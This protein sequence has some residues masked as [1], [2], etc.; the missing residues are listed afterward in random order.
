MKTAFVSQK[1]KF[2]KKKHSTAELIEIG[3]APKNDKIDILLVATTKNI[4]KQFDSIIR[5]SG[6]KNSIFDAEPISLANCLNHN[7]GISVDLSN[8]LFVLSLENQP[9]YL[10]KLKI[11]TLRS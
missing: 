11:H 10:L 3:F 6:F 5:D 1:N 2:K 7:Y 9:T 4:I 8:Q